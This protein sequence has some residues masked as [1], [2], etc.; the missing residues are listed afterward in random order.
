LVTYDDGDATP[1]L[2]DENGRLIVSIA[3]GT[4]ESA[5]FTDDS[6]FTVGT[7]KIKA[8]GALANESSPDSVDEGDIG[9]P[10]MTLDRKL[11]IRVVGATDSYRW[12]IDSNGY[13]PIDIAS[14]SLTAVK[15]SANSSAN[16]AT[17]PIYVKLTDVASSYEIHYY[18]TVANVAKNSTGTIQYDIPAASGKTFFLKSIIASAS[19]ATKVTIEIKSNGGSA[20]TKAV[21]FSSGDDLT[22][23]LFFDP[24]IEVVETGAGEYVKIIIR[25]DG[26]QAM[27]VYGT[28][29]GYLQ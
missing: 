27:D 24:P 1:L 9:I 3:G 17:N 12:N 10:R 2:T 15:I 20:E 6:A 5:I 26:N 22:K 11:L 8:I 18:N 7:D 14:Q 4:S 16:S 25:N 19:D 13:G 21:A 28:I 23:Q 29:I